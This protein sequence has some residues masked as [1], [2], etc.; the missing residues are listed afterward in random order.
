M[1]QRMDNVLTVVEGLETAK[2]FF[3][4]LRLWSWKARRWSRGLGWTR[5]SG[6][7]D[8]RAD[9]TMMRTP[10]GHGRVEL[11]RVHR[12]PTIDGARLKCPRQASGDYLSGDDLPD[13]AVA[14]D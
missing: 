4:E 12:P 3:S 1:I 7:N 10:D 11:S 9:I 5:P 13:F 14:L 2:A 8:V 6:L